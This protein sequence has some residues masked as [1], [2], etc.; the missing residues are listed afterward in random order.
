MADWNLELEEYIHEAVRKTDTSF[1][2][3]PMSGSM[4]A[5]RVKMTNNKTKQEVSGWL[6]CG[7]VDQFVM[8][9]ELDSTYSLVMTKPEA[10]RF[11]SDITVMTKDNQEPIHATLE[12][13]SPLRMGDWMI[14]QYDY[15]HALG[16]ASRTSGFELV[17]DPWLRVVYLGIILIALGSICM[18]WV[19]NRN[20]QKEK[21]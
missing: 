5:A 3:I 2:A 19:G 14:Y 7:S 21:Q 18:L 11:A 12:V 6:T 17:Y 4:P 1:Q 20:K 16:K 13:N 10:K 15:D 9:L 8:P